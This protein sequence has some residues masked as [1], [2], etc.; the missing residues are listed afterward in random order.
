LNGY[1]SEK[2][3]EV[4]DKEKLSWRSFAEEPGEEG[5]GRIASTWN[6]QGST[7]LFVLDHKGVIRYRWRGSP[8]E[9][10]ID[11]AIEKL[12]KEAEGDGNKDSK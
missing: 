7:T 2:L 5:R 3:K 11:E 12:V 9:K 6:I 8:G 10:K 1:S 4:M